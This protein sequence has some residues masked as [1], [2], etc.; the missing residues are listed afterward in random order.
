MNGGVLRGTKPN[1]P[2]DASADQKFA[3]APHEDRKN[4]NWAALLY[5][6]WC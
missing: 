5:E 2:S 6:E 3:L 4:G 1:E